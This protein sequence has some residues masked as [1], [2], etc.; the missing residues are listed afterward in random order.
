MISWSS[1]LQSWISNT[2][3]RHLN[4]ES[5]P[6]LKMATLEKVCL[7]CVLIFMLSLLII[8]PLREAIQPTFS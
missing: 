6:R 5:G 8:Q 2:R 3:K 1:Y 7:V 4:I